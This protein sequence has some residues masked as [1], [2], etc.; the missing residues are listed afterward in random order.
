MEIRNFKTH[1]SKNYDMFKFLDTNRE[2][3]QKIINGFLKSVKQIGVQEAIKI[4]K[5][6]RKD[7]KN[8]LS[9]I[10]GLEILMEG[11][12]HNGL[13]SKLKNMTYKM[14]YKS[15]SEV[16]D[17]LIVMNEH[18]MKSSPFTIYKIIAKR[19]IN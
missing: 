1:E 10:S 15:G 12:S 19:M 13:L 16:F 9:L 5:G 7:S 3:N 11:R 17:T 18:P 2:P 6:W 8:K 14:D 4:A